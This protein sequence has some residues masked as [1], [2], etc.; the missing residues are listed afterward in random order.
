M[1]TF[2]AERVI[3]EKKFRERSQ[4]RTAHYSYMHNTWQVFEQAG[5]GDMWKLERAIKAGGDVVWHNPKRG[6]RT[7]LMQA[8]MM[9]QLD[10]VNLL[11]AKGA[12]L[13]ATDRNGATA[14]VLSVQKGEAGCISALI[15]SGADVNVRDLQGATALMWACDNDNLDIAKELLKNGADQTLTDKNGNFPFIKACAEA[16][17]EVI[18]LLIRYGAPLYLEHKDG[19]TGLQLAQNCGHRQVVD[20][21]KR[22]I[23]E[24]DRREQEQAELEEALLDAEGNF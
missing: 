15:Q 4:N 9:G 3:W 20:L 14:I 24:M 11:I 6:D 12:N 13:D 22:S 23:E 19:Y 21:I 7:A 2:G 18:T 8:A 17:M 5:A 16:K 1:A 10:A